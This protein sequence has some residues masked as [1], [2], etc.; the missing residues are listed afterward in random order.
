MAA[1][2]PGLVTYIAQTL[3]DQPDE[4][5]ISEYSRGRQRIVHLKVA[6]DDMGRIIGREGRVANAVRTLLAIVP[7]E[8]VADDRHGHLLRLEEARRQRRDPRVVFDQ[9]HATARRH[10]STLRAF[11]GP[12]RRRNSRKH[13][14]APP[15]PPPRVTDVDRRLIPFG[16]IASSPHRRLDRRPAPLP[17]LARHDRRDAP[18]IVAGEAIDV[19][20]SIP[21]IPFLSMW[22]PAGASDVPAPHPWFTIGGDPPASAWAWRHALTGTQ[23]GFTGRRLTT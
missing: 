5:E 12:G 14:Q 20:P 6:P 22:G 7:G 13:S 8:A 2:V 21:T 15:F 16:W 9:Q 17:G 1:D 18:T 23:I 11:R 4:V 10:P 3:A 19:V